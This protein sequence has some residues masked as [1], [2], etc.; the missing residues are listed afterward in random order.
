MSLATLLQSGVKIAN[1]LTA[2]LQVKIKREAW[3]GSDQFGKKQYAAA[4][5]LDCIVDETLKEIQ[6]TAGQTIAISAT[7]TI[8]GD[9]LPNGAAGRRE[10]ID[11]RDRI[12]MPDGSIGPIVQ[13]PFGSVINPLTGRGFVQVVMIGPR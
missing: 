4:D 5:Y 1:N 10:P 9:V 7:L 2:S 11:P 13:S 6:N 3:I 12:T 8:V